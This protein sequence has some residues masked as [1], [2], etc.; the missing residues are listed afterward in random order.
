MTAFYEP[1]SAVKP[2]SRPPSLGQ[3]GSP[4][5]L[6]NVKE[7]A[8]ERLNAAIYHLHMGMQIENITMIKSHGNTNDSVSL[9][10]GNASVAAGLGMLGS[11]RRG[12]RP[13]T[14]TPGRLGDPSLP[15]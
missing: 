5:P 6:Q 4:F 9:H 12:D 10:Y 14:P 13:A 11:L 1:F 8:R 7:Q 15:P 2:A 3:G